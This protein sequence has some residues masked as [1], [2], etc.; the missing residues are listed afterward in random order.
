MINNDKIWGSYNR[1]EEAAMMVFKKKARYI[2]NYNMKTELVDILQRF[3][4]NT[5][6]LNYHGLESQYE[7]LKDYVIENKIIG[8]ILFGTDINKINLTIIQYYDKNENKIVLTAN[9]ICQ[10][11]INNYIG[12]GNINDL[13]RKTPNFSTYYNILI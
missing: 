3:F 4:G 6:I 8:L 5:N 10:K 7:L 11:L 13:C 2:E 1:I 9:N 12:L